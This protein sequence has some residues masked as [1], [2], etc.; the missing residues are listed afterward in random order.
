MARRHTVDKIWVCP[1]FVEGILLGISARMA[2]RRHFQNRN[3]TTDNVQPN[4]NPLTMS[5]IRVLSDKVFGMA[6]TYFQRAVADRLRVSGEC[7]A[8]LRGR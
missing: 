3:S 8:G 2:V 4:L 1:S 7:T 6:A 5:L